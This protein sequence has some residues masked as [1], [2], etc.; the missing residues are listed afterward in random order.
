MKLLKFNDYLLLESN[1]MYSNK[2]L[3]LL[4][5][6]KSNKVAEE[7]IKICAVDIPTKSNFIDVTKSNDMVSFMPDRKATDLLNS[8]GEELD[9]YANPNRCNIKVGRLAKALLDAANIKVTDKD[10]EDFVNAYKSMFD[11]LN[12][13]LR[14]FDVVYGDD[15]I[16]WYRAKNY[17]SKRGQLGSSCMRYGNCKKYFNIYTENPN[18]CS[19]VI[20]YDDNG[21]LNKKGKYKSDKIKGRALLWKAE[22]D[23]KP[24]LF[25]DRIYTN[26]DSD[27][28]L[29]LELAKK[30]KWVTK[31]DL[32]THFLGRE[33]KVVVKL[34]KS[35][36]KK[37]PYFD[38]LYYLD[39]KKDTLS[40]YHES[41]VRMLR[42]TDG[43]YGYVD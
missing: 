5:Y 34:D 7:L 36:F 24:A 6:I 13:K 31:E 2:F 41:R 11:V 16:Y 29:F 14:Q 26:Y 18:F 43:D 30:N 10:I 40:N 20:L 19:L 15:I 22:I 42:G 12:D 3:D 37:Y 27:I 21:S 4:S 32:K 25:L 23:G 39:T 1:I 38:T 17:A 9:L 33:K 28:K 35:D 8:D